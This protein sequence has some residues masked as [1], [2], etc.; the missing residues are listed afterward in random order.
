MAS[1]IQATAEG[2]LEIRGPLHP[3]YEEILSPAALD[4]LTRLHVA[5]K[6][7]RRELLV[8]RNRRQADFDAGNFPD[9]LTETKDI[10]DGDWQVAPIPAD[11]ADRR[12][13]ITGPVD[14][15]MI[16]NGLNS[17]ARVFMADFEDASSPTWENMIGG[18]INIRDAI[19]RQIDFTADN[20]KRYELCADPAVLM[21]RA[22]GWHMEEKHLVFEGESLSAGLVDFGLCFFHNAKALIERGSGPYFYLPKLESHLEARLWNDIFNFSQDALGIPR[23]TIRATVLIETIP[24]AFEMDEILF[25]LKDHS[26][27]L[28]CGRWDYIFSFI[29]CLQAHPDC[30]LPDRSQVTM[31]VHFLSSYSQLLVRTC[32]RRGVHAMGGMAAQIPIKGDPEANDRAVAKVCADKEREARN[33]HDGSWVAHPDLIAPAMS[34]FDRYLDGPNQ[35]ANKREDVV[36]AQADLLRVPDGTITMDGL[37]TNVMA[38][39]HYMEQWLSGRGAVPFNNQMEDAATAEI[40]RAQLWQWVRHPRGVLDTGERVTA[41]LVE[42]VVDE[43]LSTLRAAQGDVAFAASR[44]QDAATLLISMVASPTLP[45]FLTLAAY[46]KLD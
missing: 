31:D 10:R 15:K 37:R 12:I 38:A 1:V 26:A 42:S 17:G 22:R 7:R 4:F 2:N 19:L 13:E 11:L 30:V 3:G 46:R 41:A 8:R 18:Q 34:V 28:N 40:S 32:H 29:K 20:G 23:G 43:V 24:A 27:G 6:D 44:Y 36:V 14:R 35:I 25:E 21:V 39:V 45:T 5:F 33:G 16:V 9:F